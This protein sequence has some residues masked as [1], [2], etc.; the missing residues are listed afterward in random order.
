MGPG[1]GS[2][3]LG[4]EGQG[5]GEDSGGLG[6]RTGA[7][8]VERPRPGRERRG[9]RREGGAEPE[10]AESPLTPLAGPSVRTGGMP[11]RQFIPL[12]WCHAPGEGASARLWVHPVWGGESGCAAEVD[13]GCWSVTSSSLFVRKV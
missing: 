9:G 3:G 4:F 12:L 2:G 1:R 5:A 11:A 8:G 7:E 10:R 13:A 6:A